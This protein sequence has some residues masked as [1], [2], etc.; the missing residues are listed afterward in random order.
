MCRLHELWHVLT[1]LVAY[2]SQ[3]L[4][5]IQVIVNLTQLDNVIFRECFVDGGLINDGEF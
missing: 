3:L 2:S 4:H 1:A 5:N